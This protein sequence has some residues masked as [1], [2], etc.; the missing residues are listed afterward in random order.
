MALEG[1]ALIPA[2]VY[3]GLIGLLEVIFVHSD[4]SGMGWFK[5]AVHAFPFAVIFAFISMNAPFVLGYF[6][7]V[8]PFNEVFI[9]AGIALI[10]LLKIQ[11]AAAIAGKTGEKFTH[12]IIIALLIFAAPYVHQYIWPLLPSY[13]Q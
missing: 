10:A 6:N 8:L 13:L 3:G 12:T 11:T 1:V 4:E 9:Y 2:L 5:H 7:L